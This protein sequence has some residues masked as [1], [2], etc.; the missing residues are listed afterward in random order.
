MAIIP[1][2][3]HAP[4]KRPEITCRLDLRIGIAADIRESAILAVRDFMSFKR[5]MTA[6]P[7]HRVVISM[8]ANHGGTGALRVTLLMIKKAAIKITTTIFR[9]LSSLSGG[10]VEWDMLSLICSQS[11]SSGSFNRGIES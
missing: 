6:A 1:N 4:M 2:E 3:V 10:A 8:S 11:Q 7:I 9:Y 5:E